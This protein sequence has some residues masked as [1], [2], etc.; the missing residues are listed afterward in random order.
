MS[1]NF[2]C[3]CITVVVL[4]VLIG[5]FSIMLIDRGQPKLAVDVLSA[6]GTV[7]L[8]C[9]CF[10]GIALFMKFIERQ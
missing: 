9:I 10:W 1:K 2:L 8:I 6:Y 3:A 7:T 5:A 4:T